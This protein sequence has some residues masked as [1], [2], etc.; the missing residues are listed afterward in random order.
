M[1]AY[2]S[3]SFICEAFGDEVVITWL[4]EGLPLIRGV[5]EITNNSEI[6]TSTFTLSSPFLEDSGLYTCSISNGLPAL[7]PRTVQVANASL[8]VLPSKPFFLS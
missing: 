7:S 4:F 8:E 5:V 2:N 6:V 3:I 1:T